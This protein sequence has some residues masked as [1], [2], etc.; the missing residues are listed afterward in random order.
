MGIRDYFEEANICFFEWP[1]R[2]FGVLPTADVN[3]QLVVFNGTMMLELT[4][5]SPLGKK[6][7]EKIKKLFE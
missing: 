6:V 4:G 5:C 1:Q 2:G 7:E 3:L